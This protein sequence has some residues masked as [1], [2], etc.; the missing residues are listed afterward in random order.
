MCQAAKACIRGGKQAHG[1][2]C[3]NAT[4]GQS[5]VPNQQEQTRECTQ[6]SIRQIEEG[7]VK[8]LPVWFGAEV[9]TA[10]CQPP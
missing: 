8:A 4:G 7:H 3:W 6:C 9:R 1:R 2:P 5:T 10:Y